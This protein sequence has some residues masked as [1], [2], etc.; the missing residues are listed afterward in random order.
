MA[1]PWSIQMAQLNLIDSHDSRRMLTVL[2]G[3]MELMK[4]RDAPDGQRIVA[5]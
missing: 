4:V 2:G 5:H 1:V 3:D